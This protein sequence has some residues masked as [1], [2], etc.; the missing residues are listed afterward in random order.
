[1]SSVHLSSLKYLTFLT[2]TG[3]LSAQAQN[4]LSL[5]YGSKNALQAAFTTTL[6][7]S[8]Y[9]LGISSQISDA[10]GKEVENRKANYGQTKTGTGSQ[11][12]TVDFGIGHAIKPG[13]RV[14]FTA[15][16][17]KKDN[18]TNYSD[19]RF[20]EDGYHMIDS[21]KNIFGAGIILQYDLSKS[22]GLGIGVNSI[23]GGS[24]SAHF[25][26]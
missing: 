12:T 15:T 26:F 5:G 7:S 11:Y 4:S 21:T 24:A 8:V 17:G 19:R 1:M 18:Y 16:L 23:H 6:N 2:L 3:I 10:T 13:M 22:F 9:H 20:S 14:I 25:N